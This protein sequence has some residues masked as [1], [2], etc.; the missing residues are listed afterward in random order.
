MRI[1]DWSSD[2]C[3]SDLVQ[4]NPEGPQTF[5]A[6]LEEA[7]RNFQRSRALK[8]DGIL[9][10]QTVELLNQSRA[11][12]IPTILANM[13]RARWP[14][15]DTG[16]RF[17]LVDIPGFELTLLDPGKGPSQTRNHGGRAE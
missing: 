8:D 13:E 6:A 11:D 2:V 15:P 9:G 1:S 16:A 3:S 10:L 17:L 14:P 7:V 5:G 4:P 12:R